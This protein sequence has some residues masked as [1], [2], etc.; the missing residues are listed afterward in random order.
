MDLYFLLVAAIMLLILLIGNTYF[1][2]HNAH[3]N[4]SSF[5][6]NIVV[7]IIVVTI[8]FINKVNRSLLSQ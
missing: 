7:R 6:S 4:D 5:G 3:S 1:L 2:A 8:V